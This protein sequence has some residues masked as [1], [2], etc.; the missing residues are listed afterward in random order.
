MIRMNHS[1]FLSYIFYL[2]HFLALKHLK[3]LTK[4]DKG[5]TRKLLENWNLYKLPIDRLY[6]FEIIKE[7]VNVHSSIKWW[8][9]P[10]IYI[11][12]ALQRI[13]ISRKNFTPPPNVEDILFR[14]WPRGFQSTIPWPPWNFPFIIIFFALTPL[15]I[16]DFTLPTPRNFPLISLTGGLQFQ[17]GKP[18]MQNQ[19]SMIFV[20]ISWTKKSL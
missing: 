11:Y 5:K 7:R 16:Q 19:L 1:L 2:N 9:I 14:S 4:A 12:N 15:K 8:I 6:P 17:P 20:D 13:N 18:P 3:F 10:D